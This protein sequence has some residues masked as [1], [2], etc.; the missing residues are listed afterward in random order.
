MRCAPTPAAKTSAT[1]PALSHGERLTVAL[2]GANPIEELPSKYQPTLPATC[3]VFPGPVWKNTSEASPA[4]ET[5]RVV[6]P[7]TRQP[8]RMFAWLQLAWM[9]A[10]E[11]VEA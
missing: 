9:V 1:P 6:D 2:P 8:M 7:A 5:R 11:T 3:G 4:A 10:S